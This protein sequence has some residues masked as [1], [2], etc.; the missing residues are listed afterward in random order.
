[1][2]EARKPTAKAK[3]LSEIF[4]EIWLFPDVMDVVAL[5]KLFFR[6]L[7]VAGVFGFSE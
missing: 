5:C 6:G 4:E 7:P 3:K 2:D 1:M